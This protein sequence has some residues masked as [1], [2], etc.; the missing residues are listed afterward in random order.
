MNIRQFLSTKETSA[1][2]LVSGEIRTTGL[3]VPEVIG[4]TVSTPLEEHFLQDFIAENGVLL[5]DPAM[6]V[7]KSYHS[8]GLVTFMAVR[9]YEVEAVAKIKADK[10]Y[11]KD[12]R[13]QWVTDVG[14]RAN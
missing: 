10:F 4:L 6:S 9:E 11:I 2:S 12:G 1:Y 7:M 3:F 14:I 8:A 5:N 13:L